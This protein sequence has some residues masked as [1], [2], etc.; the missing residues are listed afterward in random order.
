LFTNFSR[1]FRNREEENDNLTNARCLDPHRH[2]DPADLHDCLRNMADDRFWK[3]HIATADLRLEL[4]QMKIVLLFKKTHLDVPYW[5]CAF[6][7]GVFPVINI[8]MNLH[9]V[10]SRYKCDYFKPVCAHARN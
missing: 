9:N 10:R 4:F 2:L 7:Q 5:P 8:L 1:S 6:R 3:S